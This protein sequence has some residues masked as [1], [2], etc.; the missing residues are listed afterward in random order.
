MKIAQIICKFRPYK[1]GM[2]E[3]A[4]HFSR[5]LA[6]NG[7][8]VVVFVPLYDK[9]LAQT[10]KID[11]FTVKRI[12]PLFKFGNAAFLPKLWKEIEGFDI[13]HIHY[14]FFGAAEII[15][16]KKTLSKRKMKLVLTYHMDVVGSG[17]LKNVF[18]F[19][20]KFIM[21]KILKCADAITASS[22]DYFK[23]SNGYNLLM[24][25][26]FHELPFGVDQVLYKIMEKDKRLMA[27]Y[28]LEEEDK[29][30]LIFSNLDKAHYFKGVDYLIK[31]FK[32]VYDMG[33]GGEG[34]K[35]QNLKLLIVGEGNMK[36]Y[37]M[38]LA[39][40]LGLSAQVIFTGYVDDEEKI[41]II[42]LCYMKVLPSIDKSESFGLVLIEAMAC[43]KP[44]IA[45]NIA[46]VRSVVEDGVNGLLCEPKNSEELAGKIKYLLDNPHIAREMGGNGKEKV[47]RIYNW[48]RVGEKLIKIYREVLKAA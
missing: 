17:F 26:K 42:N 5:E 1:G 27:K 13:I 45:S 24:S 48:K 28:N 6:N 8:E 4:Y 33:P 19:H 20:T 32:L 23:N 2:G 36:K 10:E 29:I 41:K 44:V 3:V 14:P 25:K 47:E 11:G 21:P 34:W 31:A 43:A 46:G 12:K 18:N 37:H 9:K 16:L 35:K 30:I 7:H 15:W 40:Q 39:G 22:A 38:N